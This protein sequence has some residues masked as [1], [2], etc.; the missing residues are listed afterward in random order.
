MENFKYLLTPFTINKV[1][2]KNRIVSNAHAPMYAVDGLPSDVHFHY[3]VERAKGGVGLII[4][5]CATVHPTSLGMMNLLKGWD[6]RCIPGYRKIAEEVHKYG[7]VLFSQ[8]G[9]FGRQCDSNSSEMALFAPSP[10][11]CPILRETPH[12]MDQEEIKEIVNS[13][14]RTAGFMQEAGLDGIEI[15]SPHG[16]YLIAQF[17]SPYSNIRTDEYGGSLENRCRILMEVIDAIR[18]RVGKDF[19]VGVRI[20]GDEFVKGGN[21]IDDITQIIKLVEKTGKADYIGQ[22]MGTYGTCSTII[23]DMYF[24]PAPFVYL[25]QKMKEATSLPVVATGRINDPILAEKILA[26]GQADLVG[27]T[28]ALIAD[29]E[30]P[31]K[32]QSGRL[33]EI[34]P[35]VGCLQGCLQRIFLQVPMR[36]IHNPAV[37]RESTLGMNTLKPA[38]KKKNVMIIGGGPAGLKA[39]EIAAKRGHKVTLFEARDKV[40]G[41][42]NIACKVPVREELSGVIRYLDFQMKKLKVDVRLGHRMD[43]QKIRD[44]APDAVVV[45]TGSSP[46]A[47]ELAESSR[48]HRNVLNIWEALE[49]PEKILGRVLIVDDTRCDWETCSVVEFVSGRGNEVEVVTTSVFVGSG[50]ILH[51]LATFLSNTSKRGVVF[52]PM[53]RITE[54][55]DG[56]VTAVNNFSQKERYIKDIDTII[57]NVGRR[58][59][60][61]LF[62]SLKKDIPEVYCIGDAY[63]PRW[64]DRAIRDG[65]LVGRGL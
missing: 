42:V 51:S 54:L 1:T 63:A 30:L 31:V 29:P 27:M 50:L 44:Q 46:K 40:G 36:C 45:S 21:S 7:C 53:E 18:K 34:R 60:D 19:V 32:A 12:E 3:H 24:P 58:A 49:D 35:C 38:K 20:S 39:A 4:M 52:S 25:S 10:I 23:P 55:S 14:A 15:H 33:D 9:H 17:L 64:V 26:D 37:G 43:A 5:E 62:R 8:I 57:Y 16:G 65:E 2:M 6:E 11:P 41:Q 13:Y 59:E 28:R 48:G 22:S 56:R 61:F 47:W